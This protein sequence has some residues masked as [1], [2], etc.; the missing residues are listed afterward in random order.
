MLAPILEVLPLS[1]RGLIESLPSRVYESLE[2]IRVRQ[3]SPLE[4]ATP[5]Q[6]MFLSPRVR[7]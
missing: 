6:S 7:W 1:I 3:G 2:E 5:F 4:V